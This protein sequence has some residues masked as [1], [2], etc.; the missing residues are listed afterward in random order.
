MKQKSISVRQK[1][2]NRPTEVQGERVQIYAATTAAQIEGV[3]EERKK[4]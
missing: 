1:M 2:R 4:E 3:L